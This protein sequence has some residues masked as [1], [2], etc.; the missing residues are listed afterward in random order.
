MQQRA[1]TTRNAGV[2]GHALWKD[3]WC[4]YV[5]GQHAMH[6][7]D[8]A[9]W[10][11]CSQL[12]DVRQLAGLE[13]CKAV[14]M[15]FRARSRSHAHPWKRVHIRKLLSCHHGKVTSREGR[16]KSKIRSQG[17]ANPGAV[18]ARNIRMRLTCAPARTPPG[19]R[20]NPSCPKPQPMLHCIGCPCNQAEG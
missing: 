19:T 2:S 17:R 3:A 13:L 16:E 9:V 18:H 8:D 15:D 20:P 12:C 7:S 6:W 5:A 4:M 1:F 10:S 14:G 11:S